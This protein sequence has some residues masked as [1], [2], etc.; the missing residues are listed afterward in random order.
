MTLGQEVS[1][2]LVHRGRLANAAWPEDELEAAGL[3]VLDALPELLREWAFDFLG[4][5]VRNGTAP[6]PGVLLV[7]HPL[8]VLWLRS[9]GSHTPPPQ[10]ALLS[11][12]ASLRE[13]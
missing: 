9:P 10:F 6:M 5:D 11:P 3:V 7:E 13:C 1:D 12:Q 4:E 2:R 8:E